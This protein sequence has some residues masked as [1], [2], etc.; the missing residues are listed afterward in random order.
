MAERMAWVVYTIV[1]VSIFLHGITASPTGIGPVLSSF[2]N[3]LSKAIQIGRLLK[4][5]RLLY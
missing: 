4:N 1:V 2:K 5:V 3:V